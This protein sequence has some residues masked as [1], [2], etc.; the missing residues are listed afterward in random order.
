MAVINLRVCVREHEFL[1]LTKYQKRHFWYIYILVLYEFQSSLSCRPLYS[2]QR[3][4]SPKFMGMTILT[5]VISPMNQIPS[6][7]IGVYPGVRCFFPVF[8]EL[9]GVER[10]SVNSDKWAN[11]ATSARRVAVGEKTKREAC[12]R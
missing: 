1:N 9:S 4:H 11:R 5:V 12:A 2:Y 8:L 3:C 7:G 10:A 6:R